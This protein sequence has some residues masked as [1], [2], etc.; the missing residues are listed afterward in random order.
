M[1]IRTDYL[2][3]YGIK[4]M[5]WGVRR[6]QNS[7]GSYTSAGKN[8]RKKTNSFDYEST[9][10]LRKKSYKELSNQELKTLNKRMNLESEYKRLNPRG[11]F[12]GQQVA[13]TA[14]GLAGTIGG[15]YALSNT[16]WV[17][18][19]KEILKKTRG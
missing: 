13:K 11:I 19:G 14:I 15:L 12:K 1:T 7:D 17:K 18:A 3:H 2:A 5:K 10:Q 16:Q 9:K 6:Y 8:R 4:G